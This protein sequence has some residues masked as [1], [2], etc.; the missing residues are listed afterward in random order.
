MKKSFMSETRLSNGMKVF[1]MAKNETSLMYKEVQNYVKYGIQLKEG[2][3]VFDVGANIGLFTIL[4]SKKF[5]HKINIY[6]FEPIPDIYEV[7]SANVKRLT[8][9]NVKLF[10]CGLAQESGN[11]PFTYY[12]NMTL[13]S[14]AYPIT[15]KSEIDKLKDISITNFKHFPA[16]FSWLRWLPYA[17]FAKIIDYKLTSSFQG[18]KIN[19]QLKTINEIIQE[20][21][22]KKIDLLKIDVEKSE[23]D[24]LLGITNENWHK[25]SQLFIEV[26][27]LDFR[28]NRISKML[29]DKGFKNIK[30]E[31]E[32]TLS[33][34]DIFNLYAW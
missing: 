27:N 2:D 28:I 3:I 34:S 22:I 21:Q 19:C 30:I 7:L 20:N 29:T 5:N 4:L 33:G 10:P 23:L 14:T 17:L 11:F 15:K 32:P 31:Q 13:G 18:K 6:S 16:S 8:T 9:E 24:V 26:H 25:I 1:C 12:P